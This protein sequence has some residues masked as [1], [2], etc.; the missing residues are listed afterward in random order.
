MLSTTAYDNWSFYDKRICQI[1]IYEACQVEIKTVHVCG[2]CQIRQNYLTQNP[3]FIQMIFELQLAMR[4][5]HCKFKP[6]SLQ[7]LLYSP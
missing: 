5:G 6:F 7:T 2:M 1:N 4:K 3:Q